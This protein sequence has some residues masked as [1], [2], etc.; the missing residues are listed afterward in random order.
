MLPEPYT[1]GGPALFVIPM[2]GDIGKGLVM[3]AAD[4]APMA[5]VV[6]LGADAMP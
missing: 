5:L 4:L 1:F 2:A 6:L 3:G